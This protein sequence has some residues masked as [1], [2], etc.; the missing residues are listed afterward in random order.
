M[1]I[2]EKLY[3]EFREYPL[4]NK[5]MIEKI[6]GEDS[7]YSCDNKARGKINELIEASNAQ[8]SRIDILEK[9]V[10]VLADNIRDNHKKIDF[11]MENTE[12]ILRKENGVLLKRLKEIY[13]K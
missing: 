3:Q 13:E 5:Y 10:A 7:L 4:L 12:I 2:N 1:E 9:N 6:E 11:I 8:E